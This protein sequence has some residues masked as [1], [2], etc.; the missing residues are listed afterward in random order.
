[1]SFPKPVWDQLKNTT[2]ERLISALRKDGWEL[3]ESTR[4]CHVYR[5]DDRT[6]SIHYHPKKTYGANL[7][8][9]LIDQIGW[10]ESD[11]KRLK[12]IKK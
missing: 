2:T 9:N 11:M 4:R 10:T 8:K 6:V 5:M 3:D 7:L 1:M 12:I